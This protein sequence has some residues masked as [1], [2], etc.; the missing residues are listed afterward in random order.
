MTDIRREKVRVGTLGYNAWAL[1]EAIKENPK[2]WQEKDVLG[3]V[4]SMRTIT[5]ADLHKRST[6]IETIIRKADELNAALEDNIR[7][8]LGG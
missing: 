8:V 5:L 1:Q 7:P 3:I 6:D 4:A 2:A